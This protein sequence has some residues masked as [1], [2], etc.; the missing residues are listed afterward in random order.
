VVIRVLLDSDPEPEASAVKVRFS[1]KDS[2]IG[3]PSDKIPILFDKFTQVD[4]STTRRYGGTGLGLAI[5]RQ[6]AELMGGEIGVNSREGEGS[7]F[8]FTARL[9]LQPEGDRVEVVPAD[10]EGVKVLVVDDNATNREI[11]MKRL[12]FCGMCPEEAASGGAALQCLYQALEG[13]V[14]FRLAV[15]D[16]QMPGMD[17]AT[18]GRLVKADG[19]LADLR[20]VVLT[21]LGMR[22]DAAQ[23]A[24]IGFSGYLT[25]PVRHRE[26]CGV[27]ALA[28]GAPAAGTGHA[29]AT[30]HAVRE[31]L[32]HLSM[33]RILVAEDNAVNQ[34][35]ALGILAKLGLQADAVGDG[36][37]AL[38]VLA[39]RPYDLV[40]MDVQMPRMDGYEATRLLRSRDIRS[41][42][43]P[44]RPIPVIAMTAHAMQGDR[45]RCLAAGMDDYLTK[46]VDA[47]ALRAV[48]DQWLGIPGS[49]AFS[50]AAGG[51]PTGT[52]WNRGAL[53]A[54]LMG[55][56]SMAD[57]IMA[58]FMDDLPQR[59][60]TLQEATCL[61]DLKA[62]ERSAHGLKGA[63][64]TV[65]AEVLAGLCREVEL[66]ARAGDP[67]LPR[68]RQS[69]LEKAQAD[70]LAAVAAHLPAR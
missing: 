45:E 51:P 27:L 53:L 46:P 12:S 11:L 39:S 58:R 23:F 26:L 41:A 31:T 62:V 64:A 19:R 68:L 25:K 54:R 56:A 66:A 67:D 38:R 50:S 29:L 6:L 69:A 37:E 43:R 10:L 22:G 15:V 4:T 42:R 28:L 20:M 9:E 33:S 14:P 61:G 59:L 7:E 5:S 47:G 21:S 35:V 30:S 24:E 44:E 70:F 63:C 8:W 65:G 36:A 52:A 32:P 2:G 34:E 1:V 13:G 17:G 3:I 55:D 40:L 18:L 60:R 16:M 48:L 49:P 57:S